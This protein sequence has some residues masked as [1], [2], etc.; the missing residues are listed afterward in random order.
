MKIL[1]HVICTNNQILATEK[2]S[3][4]LFWKTQ[5][6]ADLV[7]NMS[8]LYCRCLI[9]CSWFLAKIMF[10]Y[11]T[12]YFI[13]DTQIDYQHSTPIYER[14]CPPSW[15]FFEI[16]IENSR[17]FKKNQNDVRTSRGVIIYV[18]VSIKNN[19]LGI[20]KFY[21]RGVHRKSYLLRRFL[22]FGP[23]VGCYGQIHVIVC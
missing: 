13:R 11:T 5:V 12:T 8:N 22:A 4:H 1:Y 16:D 2:I 14:S 19:K 6:S 9:I 7:G 23:N 20:R 10:R 15:H 21:W 18:L 3:I 17:K